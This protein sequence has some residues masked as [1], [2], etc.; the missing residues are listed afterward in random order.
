MCRLKRI[1]PSTVFL[2]I[3]SM[4]FSPLLYAQEQGNSNPTATVASPP[5][6]QAPVQQQ[7]ALVDGWW[8]LP[9][10]TNAPYSGANMPFPLD[11]TQ[12]ASSGRTWTK[13]GK[14]M[15]AIGIPLAAVGAVVLIAGP[16]ETDYM[17]G[18][19]TGVR[20]YWKATGAIWLGIGSV[21]TIVG[22]TRRR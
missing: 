3:A 8:K 7:A 2:L 14:I 19:T 11:Q 13:A 5:S 22:L 20:V 15:T 21:L 1:T 10:M 4:L 16:K 6:T 18:G 17:T 12:S 9:S